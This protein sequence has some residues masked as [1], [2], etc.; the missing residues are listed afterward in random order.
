METNLKEARAA[1]AAAQEKEKAEQEATRK[2]E[3]RNKDFMAGMSRLTLAA[4]AMATAVSYATN[5]VTQ[6]FDHLGFVSQRTGASVQSLNSLGYAFKQVGGSSQQAIGAVESFAKAIREN[7]GVKSYVQS[8]GVDMTADTSQQLLQTVE[9]LNK[10]PYD[11]GF[12]EAGLAGISEEDYNLISRQLQQIK[13]YRAEYDTTT[14]SLGVNSEQAAEASMAFQRSLTRLQA[15]ASAL[16][17]KLMVSL[18]P[19]LKAIVDRF[20][21]WIR[22]NP[23]KVEHIM[24]GISKALVWVAEKIGAFIESITGSNGD[25]FLKKW[26]AFGERVERFAT[27]VERIA[28]A[29]VQVSNL[30]D[31]FAGKEVSGVGSASTWLLEKMGVLPPGSTGAGVVATPGAR[32]GPVQDNRSWYERNAPTILGGKPDPNAPADARGGLRARAV[33]AMRGDQSGGVAANPGAYKDVLDH[34]ARSEGTAKAPGGGYNT[35]LGYGRYLPGGQEQTLT[36][37]TLDEI[38]ALGNHMRRQPGN[39]NSSAMGRYQIVGDTLRD[40][41]RKLGLKGTDLFDEK[42][43]DRIGANLAR[44]RGADSVGLRSEWASLVG[45]NNR[46]AVEL[47]QKVDPKASTMPLERQPAS[48]VIERAAQSSIQ[49]TA[50]KIEVRGADGSGAAPRIHLPGLPRMDPGGFDVNAIMQPAPNPALSTINNNQSSRAVHQTFNTTTN[51]TGSDRPREAARIMESAF[52]NMHSLALQN[53][54]S[55]T[56]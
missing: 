53:A 35:S 39:P 16:G 25:A 19:A 41:M 26:D 15:T 30:L 31:K 34:I 21:D 20:Q 42:M 38:L 45:A 32:Q 1:L 50:P 44:Q 56:V 18:A 43:Q 10:H 5:R 55:A 8:L 3:Q 48:G 2:R 33:R 27:A 28:K 22:S 23:E 6:A 7:S 4:T 9:K 14:K 11:V 54:Q 36:T 49:V 29:S 40:Q 24:D 46:I 52:G 51:I 12:R 47:M 17:D 13:A 37:K